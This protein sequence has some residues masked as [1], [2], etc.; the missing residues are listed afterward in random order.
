[1]NI[2]Y[3]VSHS[4][5]VFWWGFGRLETQHQFI[6]KTA[7]FD[8]EDV[9]QTRLTDSMP[10]AHGYQLALVANVQYRPLSVSL[11]FQAK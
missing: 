3:Q 8:K 2:S 6:W 10:S 1:M 4:E 7:T 5:E 9:V 11:P